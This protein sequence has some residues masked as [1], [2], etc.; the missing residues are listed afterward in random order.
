M[1]VCQQ[2]ELVRANSQLSYHAKGARGIV[3]EGEIQEYSGE[4]PRTKPLG[5]PFLAPGEQLGI[6]PPCPTLARRAASGAPSRY[7][8]P[9]AKLKVMMHACCPV[10][11]LLDIQRFRKRSSSMLSAEVAGGAADRAFD[12][13]SACRATFHKTVQ[14]VLNAQSSNAV[15]RHA[16]PIEFEHEH[17]HRIVGDRLPQRVCRIRRRRLSER[18]P[19]R[20]HAAGCSS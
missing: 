15:H 2:D 16:Q 3:A 5:A 1:G 4:L 10:S 6:V 11:P 12:S 8:F 7:C 9:G 17:P 14:I 18:L 20:T 13:I 19:A